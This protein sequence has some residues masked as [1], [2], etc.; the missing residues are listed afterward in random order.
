MTWPMDLPLT[1]AASATWNHSHRCIGTGT[2]MVS[3]PPAVTAGTLL[4]HFEKL[5]SFAGFEGRLVFADLRMGPV[6]AKIMPSLATPGLWRSCRLK[7]EPRGYGA[8]VGCRNALGC[9]RRVGTC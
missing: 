9:E 7:A 4:I 3:G 8:L 2:L 5:L 6:K 1:A